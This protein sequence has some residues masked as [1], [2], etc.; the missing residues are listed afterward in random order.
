MKRKKECVKLV[1]YLKGCK[2]KFHPDLPAGA[3]ASQIVTLPAI[4]DTIKAA[5]VLDLQEDMI[6]DNVEV[7]IE[8]AK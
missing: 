5:A 4:S 2:T 7:R 3:I 8:E 6:N 1:L